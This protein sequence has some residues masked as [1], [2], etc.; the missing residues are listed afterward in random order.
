MRSSLSLYPVFFA[1]LCSASAQTAPVQQPLTLRAERRIVVID[2]VVTDGKGNP[3]HGLKPPD[4][5]VAE[6]NQ[7]QVI[8]HFDEEDTSKP[9]TTPDP[10]PIRM[11]RGVFT[12]IVNTPPSGPLNILLFDTA[13]TPTSRQMILREELKEFIKTLKPGTRIAIFGL[14]TQLYLIQGFSSDP[15]VLQN[16]LF[17]KKGAV[18]INGPRVEGDRDDH[19]AN[20]SDNIDLG[21]SDAAMAAFFAVRSMEAKNTV[22]EQK[23]AARATLAGLNQLAHYLAGLPGRKNLIWFSATFPTFIVPP[24]TLPGSSEAIP[25]S[26]S[27]LTN[28]SDEVQET[29]GLMSRAQVAIYPVD[30][31]GVAVDSIYT[32]ETANISGLSSRPDYFS[33][34]S[35]QL[36]VQSQSEHMTMSTIAD[37]TGGKAFFNTNDLAAATEKAIAA[38]ANYYT[39]SYTPTN[40]LWHGEFRPI[41]IQS[42][43]KG[44]HLAYRSGYYATLSGK[45][46]NFELLAAQKTETET[47]ALA[48]ALTRGTPG[49]TEIT[50]NVRV[51]PGPDE[52]PATPAEIEARK[53]LS[54]A[55]PSKHFILDY[56]VDANTITFEPA[57]GNSRTGSMEFICMI[58]DA[59]GKILNVGRVTSNLHLTPK[60]Y[61]EALTGGLRIEQDVVVPIKS[62]TF[63]RIAVHDR[64]SNKVGAIEVPAAIIPPPA[65]VSSIKPNP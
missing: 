40:N 10:P 51:T 60:Q 61:R 33:N 11:P 15:T 3:V 57:E 30:P 20:L 63:F 9:N 7:P 31:R 41:K 50:F 21:A 4:F 52:K 39:I 23:L 53:K 26:M 46:G 16:A 35:S 45:A 47:V 59:D 56:A 17:G 44:V 8:E 43:L 65:Q 49:A 54:K 18:R 32:A 1:L 6:Q 58:Y 64:L 24:N 38:G 28:N 22:F 37:A 42:P 12:N 2:V 48:N 55:T 62:G 25:D 19:M 13:N 5:Q 27:M 14:N 34:R 29:I 36:A